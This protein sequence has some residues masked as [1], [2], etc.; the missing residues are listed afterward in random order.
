[1]SKG[2][3]NIAVLKGD[4]IGPEVIDQG[5][6]VLKS[7]ADKFAHKFSFNEAFIGGIALEKT[8]I[9]LPDETL[10]VCKKSDAVFLGAVGSPKFDNIEPDLRPEKALLK[11]RKELNLFANLRPAIVFDELASSSA[12]KEELIKGADIMIIRELTG[13]LYF[14]QPRSFSEKSAFNTM[15]YSDFEIERIAHVAFRAA[16][17]RNK[18]LCSVDKANVLEVSRL[19]RSVVEKVAKEYSDVELT[20]MY[21]DNAA[22]QLVRYPKQFDVMLTENMFGDIL[23]DEASMITG[24]LGMLASASLSSSAPAMYEP[25]HGS[26]PDIAGQNKA[27]PIAAIMSASMMLRH[28][29]DMDKEA[30]LIE[31]AIK[32]VLK[33]G[34][35]TPDIYESGKILVGASEMGDLI[36]DKIS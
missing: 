1:M 28:S 11:I 8:G 31:G 3:K 34:Y 22:M 30:F 26:A 12:L 16:Q 5:I 19:W 9:P 18:K 33:E 27:N 24:S 13:G 2:F 7:I 23:S 14:G 21:V 36:A 15:I 4:G 6:K 35:R 25:S 10:E 29:F 17:K 32:A 20:H